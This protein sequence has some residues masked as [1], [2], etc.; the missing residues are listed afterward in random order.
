MVQAEMQ[1]RK[2]ESGCSDTN[3]GRYS[4][5]YAFSKKVICGECGA[6][7]RRHAQ[8]CRGEYVRT[9]VCNTHKIK[10]VA[11]CSQT[12]IREEELE[13]AFV[14]ILKR[15][16]QNYKE[17][18]D[19]LEGNIKSTLRQD[20]DD[21]L[22]TILDKIEELQSEMLGLLREKRNGKVTLEQYNQR[23]SEIEQE[24]QE[25]TKKR[26]ALEEKSSLNKLTILRVEQISAA[27]SAPEDIEK[28]DDE[29]C[30]SLVD[31]IVV[32]NNYTLDFHFK[33]GITETITIKR[34]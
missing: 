11:G 20:V 23:G 9:W 17:I 10:G 13:W 19:T 32:R 15:L 29:L 28:F 12:Y 2:T 33:C 5:P 22:R 14:E 26:V 21:E 3:Q 31:I 24:I 34:A 6:F 8:Y 18:T 4:S 25:L 16:I 7:Y 1:K 27:L 30:R